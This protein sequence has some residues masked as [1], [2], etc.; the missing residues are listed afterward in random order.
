MK[1]LLKFALYAFIAIAILVAGALTTLYFMYPPAKLKTM[2]IAYAKD[3]LGRE[4][5][6]DKIS[7]RLIGV[8]LDNFAMSEASTFD[9][10]T[11]A[12]AE[13]VV[14]KVALLP[15]LQKNIQVSTIGLEGFNANII[16]DKDGKFNFDDITERFASAPEAAAQPAASSAQEQK[17]ALP[18]I[19]IE[20]FYIKNS[21]ITYTDNE[22]K[23]KTEIKDINVEVGDFR[24]D[25]DFLGNLSMKLKYSDGKMNAEVPLKANFSTNLAGLELDKASAVL[26]SMTAEY[27]SM[28]VA[29]SGNA[30]N[31]MNPQLDVKGT[32]SGINNTMLKDFAPDL[33]VFT[34]PDINF[35]TQTNVDMDKSS[36]DVKSFKTNVRSSTVDASGTASWAKNV[37]YNFKVNFHL[38]LK[39]LGE[40]APDTL[41]SFNISDLAGNI[42]GVMTVKTNDVKGTLTLKDTGLAYKPVAELKNLNG[43]IE[44]LAMNN[45]KST[46]L[47]GVFNEGNFDTDFSFKELKKDLYDVVFN[48]NMDKLNIKELPK[49]S[50]EPAA[51]VQQPSASATK[52]APGVGPFFNIKAAAKTGPITVPYFVGNGAL[53]SANLTNVDATLHNITGSAQFNVEKST[54]TDMDELIKS[55]K[56][57]KVAFTVLN[58]VKKVTGNLK[59]DI[60]AAKEESGARGVQI[61]SMTGAYDFNDGLMTIK[62]T[63][64]NADLSTIKAGGTADFKTEKLA[65]NASATI[66]KQPVK[67][68][69]TGTISE[70]KGSLDV[71][72]T[73]VGIVPG[74]AGVG[75]DTV[76]DV[77][78]TAKGAVKGITDLFK[79]K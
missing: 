67:I 60:F 6:F 22:S 46:G 62:D 33:P 28:K 58:I 16:K 2:A 30:K 49:T 56:I 14:A 36:A 13:S 40:V 77:A 43:K 4:I 59:L 50:G 61:S 7:F 69:I 51:P 34:L 39:E 55:N 31:F 25:G 74:V 44:L 5:R 66:A 72:S 79:K 68:K 1:K 8:S 15:L 9:S 35:S 17:G 21:N 24:F 38:V 19:V 52:P 48:L 65:M 20:S 63:S 26:K 64:I 29:F 73:A 12:H 45:I 78:N 32:I 27:K 75:K 53:V 57:A 11:F 37:A 3:N 41:K 23:T 71:V 42:D 47:K 10:G 18:N 76:K 70:P 54:I